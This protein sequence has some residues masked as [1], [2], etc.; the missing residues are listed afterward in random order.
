MHDPNANTEAPLQRAALDTELPTQM[1]PEQPL[2][3]LSR[4]RLALVVDDD[5]LA[6]SLLT[7][8]LSAS[9]FHCL[10]ARSGEQALGLLEERRPH[11]GVLDIN[12]PGMSGAELAWRINE[13]MPDL[14][15]VA[16]S[17]DLDLWDPDD[18]VDLGFDHAFSKPFDCEEFVQIC[19]N[20][21]TGGVAVTGRLADPQQ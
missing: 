9:G 19:G 20:I 14:P 15:L 1:R 2:D 5:D 13:Q 3:S 10:P 18:L 17:G 11:L 8:L 4:E 6:R 12:L 7:E 21:C 16:V